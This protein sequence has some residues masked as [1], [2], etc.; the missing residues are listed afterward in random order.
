VI[1]I[2]SSKSDGRDL[3]TVLGGKVTIT[4]DRLVD[5]Y[6]ERNF[7]E[8]IW[9][10]NRLRFVPTDVCVQTKAMF[11]ITKVFDLINSLQL[12]VEYIDYFMLRS[13]LTSDSLTY[14]TNYLNTRTYTHVSNE[15]SLVDVVYPSKVITIYPMLFNMR[16]KNYQ[17]D[18]LNT[19]SILKLSESTNNS[20]F[21][22]FNVPN[23]EELEWSKRFESS[24]SISYSELD[25]YLDIVLH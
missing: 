1:N 13:S 24:D 7:K 14:V 19:M 3:Y 22:L 18:W 9:T 6:K 25:V 23:G 5:F 11:T 17:A 4:G 21:I 8:N 10:D 2:P 16:N 20:Y 15:T 12:N